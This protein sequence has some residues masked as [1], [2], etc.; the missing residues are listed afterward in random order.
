[1][2]PC[3]HGDLAHSAAA[4]RKQRGMPGEQP[5]IGQGRRIILGRVEHHLDDAFDVA[6]GRHKPSDV[7]AEMTREG[8]AHLFLVEQLAFDLAG[9]QHFFSESLKDRFRAQLEA[10]P[11][12]ASNQPSLSIADG[13]E[14]V[15]QA[16]L[17]PSESG[18]VFMFMNVCHNHRVFC[19]DYI[20]YSPQIAT[21]I[22]A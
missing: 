15:R 9:F 3:A 17:A 20:A 21:I 1:M 22:A 11:L 18:P 10:E 5:L 2:R 14:A 4:S 13:S 12:H 6:I 8:R 16:F 7:R 19:G